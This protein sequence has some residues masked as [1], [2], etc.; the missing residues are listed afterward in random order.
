MGTGTPAGLAQ[1]PESSV[2]WGGY[3]GDTCLSCWDALYK[4]LAS[5]KMAGK[6]FLFWGQ[7]VNS[8]GLLGAL[9]GKQSSHVIPTAFSGFP[10]GPTFLRNASPGRT[11]LKGGGEMNRGESHSHPWRS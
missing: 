3:H 7:S 6:K 8:Q 2:C 9:M 4:T 1:N 10:Q 11:S 5:G